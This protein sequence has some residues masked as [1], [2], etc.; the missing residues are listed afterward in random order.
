MYTPQT[1]CRGPYVLDC[2]SNDSSHIYIFIHNISSSL[3]LRRLFGCILLRHAQ[4]AFKFFYTFPR[5]MYL[6]T[7]FEDFYAED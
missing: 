7:K 1:N 4:A 3:Q 6:M 5:R 2:I